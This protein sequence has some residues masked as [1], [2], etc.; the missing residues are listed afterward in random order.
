MENKFFKT[1]EYLLSQK[2]KVFLAPILISAFIIFI[3]NNYYQNNK[4]IEPRSFS[5]EI[6]FTEN[7]ETFTKIDLINN[8]LNLSRAN[9]LSMNILLEGRDIGFIGSEFNKNLVSISQKDLTLSFINKLKFIVFTKNQ[10]NELNFPE[11]IIS[12]KVN[13]ETN[14][15]KIKF[16]Y[17]EDNIELSKTN[18]YLLISETLRA[19]N[20]EWHKILKKEIENYFWIVEKNKEYY[21]SAE[22]FLDENNSSTFKLRKAFDKL[23]NEIIQNDIQQLY[24]NN[25]MIDIITY[26][27]LYFDIKLNKEIE[28]FSIIRFSLATYLFI[29]FFIILFFVFIF[30]YNKFYNN[31]T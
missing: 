27:P 5:Y 10:N 19:V 3:F 25:Q 4:N 14:N 28:Y 16:M 26:T 12:E 2:Y 8:I 15:L 6:G 20:M 13:N 18:L 9:K 31:K 11:K 17:S 21:N 22:N 30:E 29:Q 24:E 7:E 1:F 23:N